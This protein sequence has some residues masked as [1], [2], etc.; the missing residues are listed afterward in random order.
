MA[1]V[2]MGGLKLTH[3]LR[4]GRGGMGRL[5]PGTL[6][7]LKVMMSDEEEGAKEKG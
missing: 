6:E 7:L 1:T 5:S 3:A 4:A 2:W